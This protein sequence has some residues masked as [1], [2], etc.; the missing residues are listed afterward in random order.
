VHVLDDEGDRLSAGEVGQCGE[1]RVEEL[2]PLDRHLRLRAAAGQQP[3]E[4][5]EAGDEMVPD[6]GVLRGEPGER[7]AERQVRRRGVTQI[8][9]VPDE[10]QD[11]LR[12]RAAEQLAQEPGLAHAG[13]ATHDHRRRRAGLRGADR[14]DEAAEFVGATDE[15]TSGAGHRPIVSWS[16]DKG[17]LIH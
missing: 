15:R 7:L 6:F 16:A 5:R 9:A 8:D 11:A 4:R 3:G 2:A 14:A 1:H 10:A 13:V 17:S 12:R